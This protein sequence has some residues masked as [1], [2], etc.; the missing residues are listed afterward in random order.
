MIEEEVPIARE[1]AKIKMGLWQKVSL[2][3]II[4]FLFTKDKTSFLIQFL[5]KLKNTQPLVV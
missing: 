3:L 2:Y 1:M 5:K 4:D